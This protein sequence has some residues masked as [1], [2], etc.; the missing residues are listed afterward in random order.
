VT[1]CKLDAYWL[2]INDVTQ[3]ILFCMLQL[4]ASIG[5]ALKPVPGVTVRIGD[6][7]TAGGKQT[8]TN[9]KVCAGTFLF[10][11]QKQVK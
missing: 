6:S 8:S 2:F 4:A 10:P 11:A 9:E 3:G 7:S 5:K 1:L